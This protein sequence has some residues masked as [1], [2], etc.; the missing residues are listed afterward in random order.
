MPGAEEAGGFLVI[1]CQFLPAQHGIETL[2]RGDDN[3]GIGIDAVPVHVL[4]DI[5]IGETV[6]STGRQEGL[7]LVECLV[8]EVLAVNEEQDALCTSFLDQPLG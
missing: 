6:S 5:R 3:L 8:A 7:E 1:F 4:H 2:N